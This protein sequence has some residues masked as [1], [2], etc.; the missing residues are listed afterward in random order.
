[1][2]EIINIKNV[3][4]GYNKKE[5]LEVNFKIHDGDFFVISG[6]NASGKSLLLKLLYMKILPKVGN[7][8]FFWRK[9]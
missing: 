7:I 3:K 4:I 8:F 2:K 5:V 1:M 9:Y 6:D